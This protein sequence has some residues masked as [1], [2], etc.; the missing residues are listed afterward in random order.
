MENKQLTVIE[1]LTNKYLDQ[2][3][4]EA[5]E[6]KKE[7]LVENLNILLNDGIIEKCKDNIQEV[8]YF[9][10]K[11]WKLNKSLFLKEIYC[12]P[13]QTRDGKYQLQAIVDYHQ[14]IKTAQQD[15]NYNDFEIELVFRDH[16]N[17]PLPLNEVYCIFKAN[18]KNNPNVWFTN[19]VFM[20]EEN[21]KGGWA[22][23]MDMLQKAAIKR[24][25]GRLYPD[26]V[27]RLDAVEIA[28]TYRNMQ[29]AEVKQT[30]SIASKI[31][32]KG[33]LGE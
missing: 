5:D 27:G 29:E 17:K 14:Y 19:I 30:T 4:S 12:I 25:L 11:C 26:T 33:V 2:F 7:W 3:I 8:Y 1:K 21:K 16:E 32:I 20:K 6:V 13:Y 28:D 18:K 15:P 31:A 23:P 10:K 24:G 9:L 22:S